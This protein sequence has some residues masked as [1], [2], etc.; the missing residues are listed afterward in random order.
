[1][2]I[3]LVLA[4]SVYAVLMKMAIWLK[5]QFQGLVANIYGILME[6]IHRLHTHNVSSA[7]IRFSKL[8]KIEIDFEIF[9]LK[10]VLD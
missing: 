10:I 9:Y 1:M 7:E 2:V 4:N 8:E 5:L 3:F 6:I